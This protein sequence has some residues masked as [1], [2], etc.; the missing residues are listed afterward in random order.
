MAADLVAL[1]ERYYRLVGAVTGESFAVPVD[2]P[3]VARPL[4]GG[5]S[6]LRA[7][8]AGRFFDETGRAASAS[9]LADAM[10][11]LEGK[12]AQAA[13]VELPLRVAQAP[14]GR[15]VVDLG[16]ED[17]RAVVLDGT[18][19][20]VVDRSPVLFR[21]TELT[22]ALPV[23]A[24][25]GDLDG[26]WDMV[27]I[28]KDDRPVLLAWL[29]SLLFPDLPHPIPGLFGEQGC[30]KTTAGR[31][32][33]LLAD[34][35][36]VPVRKA[37]RDPDAWITA[38]AGS[39]VVC[40]DNLSYVPDWLSD[41]LC[42]AV[43]GD[44]DVRRQ[45]YTDGQLVV[46]AFRRA[47]IITGI[48]VGAVRGDLADR[49]LPLD[50]HLISEADRKEEAEFWPHWRQLHPR[51]LGGLLDLAVE[52]LRVMPTVKLTS[53]PRMA[54][55]ARLLAAVDEVLGTTGFDRYR[56]RAGALAADS[57]TADAFVV[58]MADVLAS[59]AFDGTSAELLAAVEPKDE[60][61]RAPKGW[62]TNAR[63]VTSLLRR[64]APAMRRAGW[65]VD[66]DEAA[67]K[68]NVL[69]WLIRIPDRC[70][71]G[72]EEVGNGDSPTSP[73]SPRASQARLAR[74]ES[75]PSLSD[76]AKAPADVTEC[77]ICGQPLILVMPG[78][79]TCERCR[80]ATRD[81]NP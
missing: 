72:T 67:N 61:W 12:A 11:V 59:S 43:T 71:S 5:R 27:N 15:L 73:T 64:Q 7:E 45:L 24:A 51:L 60:K 81:T 65:T 53:K 2:G 33:S 79:D 54:D 37:P 9:A 56:L 18:G 17:G 19:W 13:L 39:W 21:R 46:F 3:Y 28:D 29:V 31:V 4:R 10:L 58:A 22:G 57:L 62:P 44:G 6:S 66:N 32:L 50:L 34:P 25:G 40:L 30:G 77:V 48:D 70:P 55:F 23:P 36:P 38:A 8:L 52:V 1:A 63:A 69:R 35:S 76:P 80:L 41:S 49:L 26:L 78:R 75:P 47:V 68:A 16:D 42:R 74:V 20:H 14:Y